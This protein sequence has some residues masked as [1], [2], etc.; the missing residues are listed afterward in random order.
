MLSV[1]NK[2]TLQKALQTFVTI[3]CFGKNVKT[4]QQQNKESNIKTLAG[5]G[6]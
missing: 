3:M 4:H 6:D 2:L 1:L 5:T